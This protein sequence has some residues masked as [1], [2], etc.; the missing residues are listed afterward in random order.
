MAFETSQLPKVLKSI[1]EMFEDARAFRDDS[2]PVESIRA[3]AENQTVSFDPI[4]VNESCRELEVTWLTRCGEEADDCADVGFDET[5]ANCD[6]TGNELDSNKKAYG[7][8]GCLSDSFIVWDDDCKGKFSFEEKVAKGMV[9]VM[10]NIKKK[11]N[12]A[13]IAFLAANA[14]DNLYTGVGD[15]AGDI[16]YIADG[17][18]GPNMIAKLA[19]VSEMNKIQNPVFLSGTNLW[20]AFFDAR[21]NQLNSDGKDQIAKL[22]HFRNWYFDPLNVDITL[23]NPTTLM[24]DRGSVAFFSKNHYQ[25][26][27]PMQKKDTSVWNMPD[28]E[29]SY[30]DG[31]SSQRMRYDVISQPMCKTTKSGIQQFGTAFKM[32]LSYGLVLNPEDCDGNTGLLQFVKGDNPA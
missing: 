18:W 23:S 25:N 22:N 13:G 32:I 6:I 7:P 1:R 16:T 28:P 31:T 2:T 12:A 9:D 10:K 3:I 14:Q 15:V 17:N 20:E 5:S 24:F 30:R 4:M 27:A 21:Y 26:S 8:T 19:L 29:I 11:L